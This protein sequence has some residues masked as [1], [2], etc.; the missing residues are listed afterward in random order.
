M[1]AVGTFVTPPKCSSQMHQGT[2]A[3][4]THCGER[5]RSRLSG[6]FPLLEE[7]LRL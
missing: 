5:L 7:L 2:K 1:S 3:V 4:L 6:G